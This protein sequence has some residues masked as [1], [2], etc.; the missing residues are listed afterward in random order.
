MFFLVGLK[1]RDIVD[2]LIE[3]SKS[4]G[5]DNKRTY[6]WYL[7]QLA[8][9]ANPTLSDVFNMCR[10]ITITWGVLPV[11]HE[12]LAHCVSTGF[13]VCV[14]TSTAM[15]TSSLRISSRRCLETG[16]WRLDA[17]C[18]CLR[19]GTMLATSSERG[20][21]LRWEIAGVWLRSWLLM[22]WRFMFIVVVWCSYDV[23]RASRMF[24]SIQLYTAIRMESIEVEM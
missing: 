5:S 4:A 24:S 7:Q 19:S 10:C 15:I 6:I 11:S 3:W 21:C 23:L 2:A 1:V 13:A 14:W 16:W 20:V 9:S 12:Y 22:L 17:F 8:V 18:Q